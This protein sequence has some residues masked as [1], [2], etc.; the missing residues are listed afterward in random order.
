MSRVLTIAGKELRTYLVSPMAWVVAT[1]FL[2]ISGLL[3]YNIITWYSMQSFQLMRM[4]QLGGHVNVN[5]MVF[6]PTF[7][8]MAVTLLLLV[9]IVTMR[10]LAEEKKN[11][12]AQ[13][14]FTSPVRLG[15]I[16][17]G[18][19]LAA[20][21]L[22]GGMLLLTVYMPL[23]V[24]AYGTV[25]WGP[26]F[27]GY[28]GMLLLIGAFVAMGLFASSLTENQIIAAVLTFGILLVFWL[29]GWAAELGGDFA[30]VFEHLS[31][32]THLEGFLKGVIEVKDVIYY[33]SVAAF[34]LFLTHRVLES[35]RW[36]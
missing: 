2:G 29:L 10:L 6:Q 30:K 16:V 17:A 35:N 32:I 5:R 22:L 24:W 33:V 15:E 1:V 21:A 14:L 31:I 19:F 26:I 12:T 13:L 11:R 25:D 7:Q 9:P 27:S 36:R 20:V 23:L 3:F 18:K 34:G 4:P 28:L 8:N